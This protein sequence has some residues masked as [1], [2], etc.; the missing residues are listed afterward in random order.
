[1][2]FHE[3]VQNLTL[4]GGPFTYDRHEYLI[5]PYQ[6]D[7]PFQVEEKAAQLGLTTRAML[8]TLY[9][10]RY[11]NF[12]GALYLFPSR[13]DALDFSKS[14][15]TN[16]INENAGTIGKWLKDADSAGLKKVWNSFLYIRGMRQ[17]VH[18]EVY[19]DWE[20]LDKLMGAFNVS[21]CVVD[22]LPETRNVRAFAERHKGR[23]YLNYYN[24][25][26]KG[27]YAWNDRDLIVSCNRTESL[28]ASHREIADQSILLPKE[29]EITREFAQHLHNVAKRLEENEGTGSKRYV[30]MKLGPDHFRHSFNYEAMARQNAQD[31]LFPNL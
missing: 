1:M 20:D 10:C 23:I 30:Y 14:R 2:P 9:K 11:S 15:I 24:E 25:H 19:R 18:I 16:L 7:H 27:H 4:D 3:W 17:I 26:Q 22:A 8:R 21:R 28:D 6:D 13:T 31:F 29:C 5:E 12:R